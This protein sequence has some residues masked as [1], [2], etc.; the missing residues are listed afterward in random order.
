MPMFKTR[1]ARHLTEIV[2]FTER[3]RRP[4]VSTPQSRTTSR[5][6]VLYIHSTV[7]PPPTD[8]QT[9]RFCLLPDMLEGDILQPIWCQTP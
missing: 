9:D 1:R 4:D 2:R 8:P 5:K 7:Q 6:R 3:N